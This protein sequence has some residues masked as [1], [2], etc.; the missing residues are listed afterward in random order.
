M[1]LSNRLM[2]ISKFVFKNSIAADIGTDHGLLPVYLIENKISKLVIGTDIS[3]KS[4]KKTIDYIKDKS[5]KYNIIPRVGDGLETIKPFEID[6]L[7]I[8][9]MGGLL[10]R[11]ILEKNKEVRDSIVHFIF[12]PMIASKELRQYLIKNRFIIVDESLAKEG[13]KFYEI[14]YAKRGWTCV[15]D[16]I[17]YEVSNK[18]IEKNHPLLKEFLKYKINKQEIILDKLKYETSDKSSKRYEEVG[19][20]IKDYSNILNSLNLKT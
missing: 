9:G 11:D 15:E 17:N 19:E 20:K 1:A 3:E 8:S 14:I 10:I 18:L 2:E 6:T 12:Q 4:L 7:I 16:D 13:D 5:F